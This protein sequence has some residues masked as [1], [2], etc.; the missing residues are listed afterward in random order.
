LS[1]VWARAAEH[2]SEQEYIVIIGY[3]LPQTDAFFRHLYALGSVGPAPLRKIGVHNP[4][5]TGA[6]DG[7]FREI[8]RPGAISRDA[9][10]PVKFDEAISEITQLF[11]G[12]D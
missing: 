11:P 2:I 1:K 3:S 6:V 9:Y 7:R 12:C 8:L 5:D 10:R 4:D